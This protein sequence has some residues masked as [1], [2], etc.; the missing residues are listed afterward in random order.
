MR[1]RLLAGYPVRLCASRQARRQVGRQ[2]G[3]NAGRL[4]DQQAGMCTLMRVYGYAHSRADIPTSI[5]KRGSIP[6][7][8]SSFGQLGHRGTML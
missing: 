8:R 2:D 4:A 6:R 5:L 3:W 1:K 7:F